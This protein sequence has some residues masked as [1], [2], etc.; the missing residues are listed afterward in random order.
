MCC[1]HDETKMSVPINILSGQIR[2]CECGILFDAEKIQ[3]DEFDNHYIVPLSPVEVSK[4][5][6]VTIVDEL[7]QVSNNVFL[8][9]PNL[10]KAIADTEE[11]YEDIKFYQN[12]NEEGE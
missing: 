3:S 7:N 1:E 2:M 12:L 9:V 10:K 4:F 8:G 11:E 6:S 5:I